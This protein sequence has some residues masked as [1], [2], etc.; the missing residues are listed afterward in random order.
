M[1][2]V[3]YRETLDMVDRL[4]SRRKLTKGQELYMETL[5]QLVQVYEARVHD[6]DAASIRG[7]DLLRHLLEEN[8]M[9]ASDL[10]RVLGVYASMGS[11][12]LKGN[13][14]S[15]SPTPAGSASA[16]GCG[17]TPSWMSRTRRRLRPV[18]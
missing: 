11:K 5:V 10:A 4:M 2:D 13:G 1:D 17:S 3:Q 8:D 12:I 15:R 18:Q 6:I 16:S 14:R 9:S 7:I